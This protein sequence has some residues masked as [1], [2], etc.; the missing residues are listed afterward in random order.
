MGQARGRLASVHSS[1][2]RLPCFST[3]AKSQRLRVQIVSLLLGCILNRSDH[4]PAG[5]KVHPNV[6]CWTRRAGTHSLFFCFFEDSSGIK[7]G[8]LFTPSFNVGRSGLF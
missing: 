8:G 1:P 6:R 4:T 3:G 2:S 7:L 5:D